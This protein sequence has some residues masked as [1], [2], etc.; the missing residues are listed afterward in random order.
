[1]LALCHQQEIPQ[2]PKFKLKKEGGEV[3]KK[4]EKPQPFRKSPAKDINVSAERDQATK[5]TGNSSHV[6]YPSFKYSRSKSRNEIGSYKSAN[7][8]HTN[9]V[10]IRRSPPEES[11]EREQKKLGAENSL[12]MEK[13]AQQDKQLLQNY[14]QI[15]KLQTQVVEMCSIIEQERLVQK[16][17]QEEINTFIRQQQQTIANARKKREIDKVTSE[18]PVTI[19]K[20]PSGDQI[21]FSNFGHYNPGR[22]LPK[23]LKNFEKIWQMNSIVCISIQILWLIISS[24]GFPEIGD[25]Y[26]SW[27]ANMG[28]SGKTFVSVLA[29][30]FILM[31]ILVMKKKQDKWNWRHLWL[32]KTNNHESIPNSNQPSIGTMPAMDH[33]FLVKSDES[34]AKD[35]KGR[36]GWPAGSVA[37]WAR[38]WTQNGTGKGKM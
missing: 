15:I 6:K 22:T 16:C 25:T 1:M 37:N 38:K 19:K 9:S 24:F 4:K 8:F 21:G 12:L 20:D 11:I 3:K 17:Q 32:K 31:I 7:S 35:S 13:L 5:K 2:Q 27:A 30:C 23:M 10:K 18:Q 26:N 28:I 29:I 34:T 36:F 33:H 14:Q